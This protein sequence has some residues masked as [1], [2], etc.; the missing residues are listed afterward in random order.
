MQNKESTIDSLSSYL[1][2]S[3]LFIQ[4]YL[5]KLVEFSGFTM[6]SLFESPSLDSVPTVPTEISSCQNFE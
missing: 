1:I 2:I 6:H 3:C 4:I 5:M